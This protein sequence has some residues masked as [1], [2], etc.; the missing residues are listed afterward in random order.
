LGRVANQRKNH[1]GRSAQ[2]LHPAEKFSA[3]APWYCENQLEK[4][5]SA[6]HRHKTTEALDGIARI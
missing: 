1:Y 3:A 6:F 2:A 5:P 4:G